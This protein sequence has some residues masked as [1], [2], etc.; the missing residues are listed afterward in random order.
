M[1][2]IDV[3]VNSASGKLDLAKKKRNFRLCHGRSLNMIK[4]SR[5]LILLD[6]MCSVKIMLV[7]L[8]RGR[9]FERWIT[10]PVDKSYHVDKSP[11]QWI[12]IHRIKKRCAK[13]G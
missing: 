10:Y 12:A 7:M 2:K 6:V 11:I 8:L 4:Q 9:L 3:L 13:H 5:C 1:V